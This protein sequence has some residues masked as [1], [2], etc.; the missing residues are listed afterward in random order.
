MMRA[1]MK[2]F[3]KLGETQD[4]NGCVWELWERDNI[5]SLLQ[6]GVQYASSFVYGSEQALT[7][8]ALA[9][10]TRATQ[11]IILFAGLG[12]GYSLA[13]AAELVIRD[14]AKF[15]VAEPVPAIVQWVSTYG[16]N[17][18]LIT[19]DPRVEIVYESAASICSK[20]SGSLHAIILKHSH[21]QCRLTVGEAQSYFNALKGGSML[22]ISIGKTDKKLE[23]TL[24]R[25][26]FDVRYSHVPAAAK[27]KQISMHTLIL[28]RRGRFVSFDD[29]KEKTT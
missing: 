9:P 7:E 19:N 27:G 23:T 1:R 28:A 22:V 5:Y 14:K 8:V 10:V 17:K 3:T 16:E 18:E 4:A 29:R 24:R 11:P 12:L 26:G 20:R 15:I 2:A 25:A 13:K 21:A 6:D